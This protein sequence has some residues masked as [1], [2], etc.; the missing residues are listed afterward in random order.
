MAVKNLGTFAGDVTFDQ[1]KGW[2]LIKTLVDT[3]EPKNEGVGPKGQRRLKSMFDFHIDGDLASVLGT[4]RLIEGVPC[5]FLVKTRGGDQIQVG[6]ICN[7]AYATTS[8]FTAGKT[9]EDTTGCS[10]TIEAT[11][12][13]GIYTGVI[14]EV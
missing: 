4:Q 7:P 5:I 6:D 9:Q 11:R 12:K 8:S 2:K 14:T 1:G 3:S 13:L 10:F